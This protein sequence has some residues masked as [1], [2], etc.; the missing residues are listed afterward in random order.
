MN[1]HRAVGLILVVVLCGAAA[2]TLATEPADAISS[3]ALRAEASFVDFS[4]AAIQTRIDGALGFKEI[5]G[6]AWLEASPLNLTP[7]A[8]GAALSLQ[9]DWLSLHA[10]FDQRQDVSTFAVYGRAAPPAWILVN[11]T[12]TVL[13]ELGLT[14]SS[15]VAGPDPR[16]DIVLNPQL[17]GVLSTSGILVK[18]ALNLDITL[19]SD[20]IAP[21]ITQVHLSSTVD[22]GTVILTS[23]VSF[24]RAFDALAGGLVGDA[25]GDG[26]W[27]GAVPFAQV[28]YDV[29][30]GRP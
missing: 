24:E 19:G 2:E 8:F 12:P 14:V 4:F 28:E 25:D 3:W 23:T 11:G 17:T 29:F 7:S 16:Q 30:A 6:S 9:R 22:L 27:A 13:A 5:T 21:T 26:E 18:P 1:A 10:D 15:T 20:A